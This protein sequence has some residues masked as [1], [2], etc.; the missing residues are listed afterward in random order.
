[1]KHIKVL[2]IRRDATIREGMEAIQRGACWMALVVHDDGTLLGLITDGDVRRALLA[3][4]H[5]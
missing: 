4:A 3:G 1:M 5:R 2:S